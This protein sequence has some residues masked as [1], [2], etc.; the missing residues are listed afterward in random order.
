MLEAISVVD[1]IRFTKYSQFHQKSVVK[2]LNIAISVI[3]YLWID[4][5]FSNHTT[6]LQGFFNK[7]SIKK[8][9]RII[10]NEIIK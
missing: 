2:L 9:S 8:F 7:I 4:G 3:I 1:S 6:Y 10:L 5:F